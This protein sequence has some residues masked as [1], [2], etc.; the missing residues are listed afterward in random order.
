MKPMSKLKQILTHPYLMVALRLYLSY[1]FFMSGW[2]K[3]QHL[4]AFVEIAKAYE[5]L[6]DMITEIYARILPF[7][8]VLVAVYL[9]FG[10]LTK[11][12]S[13]ITALM[14]ISFMIATVINLVRGTALTNCGCFELDEYG[15]GFGWHIFFRQIWYMTPTLLIYFGKHDFFSLDAWLAKRKKHRTSNKAELESTDEPN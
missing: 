11:Y 15:E 1:T 8:E 6:P 5:I 7:V 2:E 12:T 10:L 4:D 13:V 9:L 3:I 14:L